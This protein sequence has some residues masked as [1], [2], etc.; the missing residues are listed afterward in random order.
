METQ[1]IAYNSTE[2]VDRNRWQK[3]LTEIATT[4]L[5]RSLSAPEY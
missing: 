5:P 2:I 1:P 4:V 3:S